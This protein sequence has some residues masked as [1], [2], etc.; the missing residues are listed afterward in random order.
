L[1]YLSAVASPWRPA[2]DLRRA[3]AVNPKATEAGSMQ[4]LTPEY[5]AQHLAELIDRARGGEEIVIAQGG[6]PVVRLVPIDDWDEYQDE[7]HAP[8]E[9]V[10]EAFHGD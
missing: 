10:D 4:T 1:R 3:A 5:A 2:A 8:D 7:A 6:R 9:E